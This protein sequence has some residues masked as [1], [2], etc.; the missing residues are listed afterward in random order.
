MPS[1]WANTPCLYQSI[2]AR[3]VVLSHHTAVRRPCPR[4]VAPFLELDLLFLVLTGA[5]PR[6]SR[7][8]LRPQEGGGL[9]ECI[10]THDRYVRCGIFFAFS[11]LPQTCC[12]LRRPKSTRKHTKYGPSF[13]G[14]PLR[15]RHLI[16][17]TCIDYY[18]VSLCNCIVWLQ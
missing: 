17:L 11:F 2:A 5:S 10:K 12:L 15:R 14:F 1:K 16:L 7:R 6:L 18:N 13:P 9:K 8:L 4:Y 3:A